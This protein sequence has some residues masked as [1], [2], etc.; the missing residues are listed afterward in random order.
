[1]PIL[2]GQVWEAFTSLLQRRRLLAKQPRGTIIQT[3]WTPEVR[4]GRCEIFVGRLYPRHGRP[5]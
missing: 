4:H 3:D 1:M 5:A 2:F